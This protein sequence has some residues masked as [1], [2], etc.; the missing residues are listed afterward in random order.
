MSILLRKAAMF[1]NECEKRDDATGDL[2]ESR[3]CV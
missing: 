3:A 1:V 2:Q